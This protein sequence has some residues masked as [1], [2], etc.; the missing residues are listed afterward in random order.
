MKAMPMNFLLAFL[1][2]KSLPVIE[3]IVRPHS[4]AEY[5]SLISLSLVQAPFLV[6]LRLQSSQTL[7]KKT[8]PRCYMQTEV[9]FMQIKGCSSCVVDAFP[10]AALKFLKHSSKPTLYAHVRNI[11][12][13]LYQT[14]NTIIDSMLHLCPGVV[15]LTIL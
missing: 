14:T 13:T 6:M 12:A 8:F 10:Q 2:I 9:V 5:F 4:P 15:L 11:S 7:P 1:Y 3:Q